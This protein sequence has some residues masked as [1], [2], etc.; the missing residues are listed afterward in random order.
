MVKGNREA[1]ADYLQ[2]RLA[3]VKSLLELKNL[4]HDIILTVKEVVRQVHTNI[5][6]ISS[7]NLARELA[8]E[9]LEAEE[10][11]FNVGTA[12]ILDVLNAQTR[13]A[14]AESSE[15]QAIV[16]YNKALINLEQAKGTLLERNSIHLTEEPGPQQQSPVGTE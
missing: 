11:K 1:K 2:V 8:E 3:R 5:M 9:R 6:R 12:E 14:E 16:D 4:E 15:R 13:L 10:E 7:M